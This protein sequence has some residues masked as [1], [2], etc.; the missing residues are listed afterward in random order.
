MSVSIVLC[1]YGH[2]IGNFCGR[3]EGAICVLWCHIWKS[4][5]HFATSERCYLSVCIFVRMTVDSRR[6]NV[7][8]VPVCGSIKIQI[9]VN[10][11]T[12]QLETV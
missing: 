3:G 5:A 7:D 2:V 10:S 1:T 11:A 12:P 4:S 6:V 8:T 9:V